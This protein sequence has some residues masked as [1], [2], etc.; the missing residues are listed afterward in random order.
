MNSRER[1]L[2]ALKGEK[3][4]RVP[5]TLFIQSQGHFVTQLEPSADPWDFDAAQKRIIDFQRRLGLDVHV[6]MLFFNSHEPVFAHW[7]LLNFQNETEDWKVKITKETAGCTTKYHHL[8]STPEGDLSQV[9]CVN[10]ERPGIFMFGSAEPPIKT[11]EDLKIAMKYEPGYSEETKQ[12]MKESVTSV[13]EYLGDDG[14]I[15]AWTNGGLFSNAAGLIDQTEL[16]SLFLEDEEYYDDLMKFAK[17]RVFDYTDAVLDTGVDA[18]CVRGNAA[19]GF[20]GSRC[21]EEYVLPYEREYIEHCQRRGNPVIYHNC[22]KAMVLVPSYLKLG[23]M[24][25]EPWSPSPLGDGNLDKLY[26]ELHGE[27]SVTSGVDQV[28]VIQNGS[29]EDVRNT[30]L[31][32]MEKGKKFDSFIMQNV[33]F[34]EFGTP[35]ENVEEYAKTALENCMY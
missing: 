28:N 32:V 23:A 35:I 19:G 8:I 33:D 10:E 18:I 27:F 9:F 2:K 34:L 14:I 31:E 13:R 11:P 12:K 21:F 20:I 26:E 1:L 3:T 30:T 7:D 16:Y 5:V 22:G 4:D 15:S 24:N 6:R 29:A 17:K 25:I